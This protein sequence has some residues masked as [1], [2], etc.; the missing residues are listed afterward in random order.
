MFSVCVVKMEVFMVAC[1][2]VAKVG[3]VARKRE[4]NEPKHKTLGPTPKAKCQH[5]REFSRPQ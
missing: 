3:K 1:R 4:A 5:H 2:V